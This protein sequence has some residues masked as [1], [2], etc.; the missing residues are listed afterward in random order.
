[1]SDKRRRPFGNGVR[2]D[3]LPG[4]VARLPPRIALLFLARPNDSERSPSSAGYASTTLSQISGLLTFLHGQR[5]A[6]LDGRAACPHRSVFPEGRD[7][8]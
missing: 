6:D 4:R 2:L 7:L 3:G 5:D 1:M 8:P